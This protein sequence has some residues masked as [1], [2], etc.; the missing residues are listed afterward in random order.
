[1]RKL[2]GALQGEIASDVV[3]DANRVRGLGSYFHYRNSTSKG[4]EP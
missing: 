4:L 2:R 3:T 1:M